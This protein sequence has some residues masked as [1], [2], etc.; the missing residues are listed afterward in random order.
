MVIHSK[1]QYVEA[2]YAY[3][4]IENFWSLLSVA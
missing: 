1:L 3:H 2:F 4:S